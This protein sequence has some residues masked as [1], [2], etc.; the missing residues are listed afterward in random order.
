MR[1]TTSELRS[2]TCTYTQQ[3][4]HTRDPILVPPLAYSWSNVLISSKRSDAGLREMAPNAMRP[5]VAMLILER[6]IKSTRDVK[7]QFC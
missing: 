4:T 7:S 5:G 1:P 6:N 2:Y 3:Y